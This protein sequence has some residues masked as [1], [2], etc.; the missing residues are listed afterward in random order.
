MNYIKAYNAIIYYRR[1]HPIN[2]SK[3]NYC[4]YHHIIPICCNGE[5]NPRKSKYNVDGTNLIGLTAK[6]H[7]VCHHLLIKIYENTQYYYKLLYAYNLFRL[8]STEYI[9]AK[10]RV[11]I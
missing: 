9:N 1:Q 3:D 10:S 8:T 5:N 6:E 4:E 11:L 7:Y 2:R